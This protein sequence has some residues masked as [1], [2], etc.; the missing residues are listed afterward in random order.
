MFESVVVN[1]S[2]ISNTFQEQSLFC[3]AAMDVSVAVLVV[4]LL[5]KSHFSCNDVRTGFM[6]DLSALTLMQLNK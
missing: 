1:K 3:V 4:L 6:F 5:R 2:F